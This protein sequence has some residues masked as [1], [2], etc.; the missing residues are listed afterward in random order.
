[1]NIPT[2]ILSSVSKIGT[3]LVEFIYD[4]FKPGRGGPYNWIMKLLGI[5]IMIIL[6]ILLLSTAIGIGIYIICVIWAYI[7]TYY[8]PDINNIEN[9]IDRFWQRFSVSLS[10]PFY[11]LIYYARLKHEKKH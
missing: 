7:L 8:V 1:M 3:D 2:T 5:I 11:I 4:S 6:I 9:D 10:G